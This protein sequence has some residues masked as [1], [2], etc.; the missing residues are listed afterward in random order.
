MQNDMTIDG[1]KISTWY[2][3]HTDPKWQAVNMT[4]AVE[5]LEG[6]NLTDEEK[7]SLPLLMAGYCRLVD[8]AGLIGYCDTEF[9]AIWDLFSHATK[10]D[11]NE[12]GLK[13]NMRHG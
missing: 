10:V 7:T 13:R 2:A 8:E 3:D 5:V 6:Y 1:N 4:V 11:S 9:G 12:P